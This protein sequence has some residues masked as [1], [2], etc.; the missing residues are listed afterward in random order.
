MG[1]QTEIASKIIEH[2]AD[3]I[4]VVKGNQPQL[5]EHIKDEFLLSKQIQTVVN[6]DLDHGRIEIRKCSVITEFQ[7]IESNN[8]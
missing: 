2:K 4:L 6:Q 5:L 3:Y 7:F 1:T 8:D